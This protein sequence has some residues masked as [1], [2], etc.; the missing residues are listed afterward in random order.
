MPQHIIETH[1]NLVILQGSDQIPGSFKKVRIGKRKHKAGEVVD[2]HKRK[3]RDAFEN[4]EVAV[5]IQIKDPKTQN[6]K[7][8]WYSK[9]A[10][11][12]LLTQAQDCIKTLKDN[13]EKQK[14]EQEKRLAEKKAKE[15][16]E[17]ELATQPEKIEDVQEVKSEDSLPSG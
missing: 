9:I 2:S 4:F 15:D 7:K 5:N 6:V 12:K 14:L 3:V 10:I 11:F 8:S 1:N 13:V 16:A 17:K